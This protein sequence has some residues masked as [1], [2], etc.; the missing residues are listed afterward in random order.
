[1][2]PLYDDVLKK[3]RLWKGAGMELAI[4]SSGSVEAQKMFFGHVGEDEGRKQADLRG[5]FEPHWFDTVNAGSKFEG[6]SYETIVIE[7]MISNC[8]EALF[9]SD[10]IKGIFSTAFRSE[11]VNC[12]A[13]ARPQRSKPH[14]PRACELYL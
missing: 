10:H 8:G 3:I 11:T 13:D 12:N 5:L 14:C 4:F 7:M 2:T 9:L 1:M 6:K